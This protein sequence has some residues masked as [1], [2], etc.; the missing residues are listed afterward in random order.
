MLR[1]LITS[2]TMVVCL[3][4][5]AQTYLSMGEQFGDENID[6]IS[7]WAQEGFTFIPAKG[8]NQKG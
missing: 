2:L 7:E 8:E 3:C 1:F 5:F 4:S 6:Q